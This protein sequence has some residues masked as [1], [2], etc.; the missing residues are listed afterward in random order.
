MVYKLSD[1]YILLIATWMSGSV[2]PG[3]AHHYYVLVI[4]RVDQSDTA[5]IEQFQRS[6]DRLNGPHLEG[7]QALRNRGGKIKTRRN[8]SL[9]E[10]ASS[11]QNREQTPQPRQAFSSRCANPSLFKTMASVGHR[12]TQMPQPLQACWSITER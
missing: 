8:P 12:S 9:S 2:A 6:T 1:L 5:A 3:V 4:D 7:F 11:G 10:M